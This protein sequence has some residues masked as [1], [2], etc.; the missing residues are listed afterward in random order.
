MAL[1]V[2]AELMSVEVAEQLKAAVSRIQGISLT[3]RI[4]RIE[5]DLVRIEKGELPDILIIEITD[6]DPEDI[7][8]I[9]KVMTDNRE[10]LIVYIVYRECSSETMRKL[11]KAGVKE[12]MPLPLQTQELVLGLIEMISDRRVRT[13]ARQKNGGMTAFINAKGGAGSTLLAT[14]T[15]LMLVSEYKLSTALIDF[16]VQFGSAAIYLDLNPRSNIMDALI[17]VDR[18]D[19]VF[20]KA[21]MTKHKSGLDVLA[22]P[23]D[24]EPING[25]ITVEGVNRLLEVASDIYDFVILDVPRLFTPWTI[26]A[27]QHADPIMLVTHHDLTNIRDAKLIMD[28]LPKMEISTSSVEVINN[29]AMTKVEETTVDSLKETLHIDRVHRVRNDYK[30]AIHAEENG[31][32]LTEISTHSD[33]TKDVKALAHYLAEKHLGKQEEEHLAKQEEK[34]FLHSLFGSK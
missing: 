33:L 10:Q 18:I 16:D 31:V 24:I 21:L 17:D 12:F 26:A 22:S 11:A 4:P 30:T 14:N 27:L 20:V 2:N 25:I 15:A 19:P 13:H 1:K 32:P 5:T 23:G 3:V 34:G 7:D 8:N 6:D 28:A 29:R 9:V